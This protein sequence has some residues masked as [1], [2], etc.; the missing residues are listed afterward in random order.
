MLIYFMRGT[1]PWRKIRAPMRQPDDWNEPEG[2][3]CLRFDPIVLIVVHFAEYNPV[4][5]TWNMIRDAK[6]KAEENLCQGL[7]PEIDVFY[8]Q[9]FLRPLCTRSTAHLA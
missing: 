5:L 7:P 2:L 9:V 4:S 6:L 8:R 3:S 1:L